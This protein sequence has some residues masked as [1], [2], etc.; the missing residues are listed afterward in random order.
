MWKEIIRAHYPILPYPVMS[1]TKKDNEYVVCI[2]PY[3]N[4]ER[5]QPIYCLNNISDVIN[6][7]GEITI[8][9]RQNK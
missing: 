2:D 9:K 1:I 7:L 4:F 3:G 8:W 6:L 5:T